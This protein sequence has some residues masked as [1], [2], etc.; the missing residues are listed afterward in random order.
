MKYVEAGIKAEHM[1]ALIECEML[2]GRPIQALIDE[3]LAEYIECSV[4]AYVE[5][6]AGR[7]ATA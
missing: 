4:S 5:E 7:T 3:A 6:Q 1:R 2:T